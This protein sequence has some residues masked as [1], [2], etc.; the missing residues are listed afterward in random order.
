MDGITQVY[1]Q[2]VRRSLC[3]TQC[4]YDSILKCEFPIGTWMPYTF[5]AATRGSF[6]VI[7][8]SLENFEFKLTISE[9]NIE[10]GVYYVSIWGGNV[11]VEMVGKV[12]EG[13][14]L[15]KNEKVERLR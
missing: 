14:E 10:I 5:T 11:R 4:R 2:T 9:M 7:Q 12:N 3:S 15:T 13:L 6:T 1:G 8:S